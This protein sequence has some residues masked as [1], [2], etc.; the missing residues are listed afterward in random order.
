[1]RQFFFLAIL[2]A[3]LGCQSLLATSYPYH[4]GQRWVGH[5]QATVSQQGD[6]LKSLARKHDIGFDELYHANLKLPIDH[7]LPPGTVVMLPTFYILPKTKPVGIVINLPEK[8]MFMFGRHRVNT[9]PVGIGREGWATPE[10]TLYVAG[11]KANPHWHVPKA[12][13]E[14]QKQNGNV[15]P[16]IIPPGPDNPLGKYA[17]RLSKSNYLIHGTNEPDG[18]GTRSSAGCLRMYPKDIKK[19][20][21]MV[22]HRTRVH[23]VNQ[24]FKIAR[25]RG[26]WFLESHAPLHEAEQDRNAKDGG[27]ATIAMTLPEAMA[28]IARQIE[29]IT[30]MSPDLGWVRQILVKSTGLPTPIRHQSEHTA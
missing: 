7:A 20:F 29:R 9:F 15:L 21:Q 19:L 3:M 13:L 14:A 26:Q 12:V 16:E 18:V 2:M 25:I 24:P 28:E 22:K 1:M 5:V 17:I 27:A 23:I 10:G 8:R 4:A 30:H 11:K 6:T